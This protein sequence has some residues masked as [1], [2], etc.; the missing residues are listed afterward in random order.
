MNGGHDLGGMHGFGPIVAEPE[1]VEPVFH[2]VWERTVFS[3]SRGLLRRGHWSLDRQRSFVEQQRP[4]DYLRHSY[5]ENWLDALQ[6]LVVA[7]GLVTPEEL[8]AGHP[9]RHDATP[10]RAW[11]PTLDASAPT[12]RFAVGDTVRVLNRHPL[13]HTRAPR[14][15]RGH[16][17]QVVAQ[18]GAEPLADLAAENVYSPEN[19]YSVR[20]ESTE[21]WGPDM[22]G[23]HCVFIDL[24]ESY[25]EPAS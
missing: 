8:A 4:A 25:L 1:A 19:V 23:R 9:L 11:R 12:P 5:Y 18:D 2:T 24:W 7:H 6:R 16:R 3:M 10:P 15:A 20:F 13:G 14:Y 17:G 22:S 21:L